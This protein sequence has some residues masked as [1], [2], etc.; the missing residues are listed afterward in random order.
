MATATKT[1]TTKAKPAPEPEVEEIDDLELDEPEDDEIDEVE[2][3]PAPKKATKAKAKAAAK[4][5]KPAFGTAELAA[6]V[7]EATGKTY[8]GKA[9]RVLLR[10]M[11]KDG[12]IARTVGEDRA[13]YSFT[14]PNDPQV[15]AIVK[16][17][18][19]GAIE[20]E[21]KASLD[22]VKANKASKATPAK[23]TK[24][25]PAAVEAEDEV[26]ELEDDE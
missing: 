4:D 20:A 10:K 8:D 15:K 9:I 18:K 12:V 21:R 17:V 14:G 26:E 1:R 24:A 23:S 22:K 5:D 7:S 25:R 3:T 13:R 11:A 16:A 2:D 6:H 19:S